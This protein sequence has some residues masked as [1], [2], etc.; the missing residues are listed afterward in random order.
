MESVRSILQERDPALLRR[1][2]E[3]LYAV[4]SGMNFEELLQMA[5]TEMP[6]HV[7]ANFVREVRRRDKLEEFLNLVADSCPCE[8]AAELL[9]VAQQLLTSYLGSDHNSN[10]H[11]E[12]GELLEL[13]QESRGQLKGLKVLDLSILPGAGECRILSRKFH[14][15]MEV[16]CATVLLVIGQFF[17]N[18]YNGGERSDFKRPLSPFSLEEDEE[19][20]EMEVGPLKRRKFSF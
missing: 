15:F 5:G 7:R 17:E 2:P 10:P 6:E 11:V 1:F 14:R 8:V 9:H 18:P 19:E 3:G 4:A 13:A 16:F 20:R 12:A